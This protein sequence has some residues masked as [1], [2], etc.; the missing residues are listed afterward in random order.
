MIALLTCEKQSNSRKSIKFDVTPE[1]K[2]VLSRMNRRVRSI[3][4]NL[5][6]NAM[7]IIC[8]GHG[9]TAIVQRLRKILSEQ[10]DA[11]MSR[12][13]I[14]KLLEELQAQAEVGLCFIG[15]KH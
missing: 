5:P 6:L 9:D 2:D 12:E 3:Y 1:L 13:N 14:V 15:V 8:T 11:S 7:L 10:T 4:S